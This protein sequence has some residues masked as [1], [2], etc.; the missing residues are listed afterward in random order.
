MLQKNVPYPS[1]LREE[2]MLAQEFAVKFHSGD[3]AD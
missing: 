1:A 2:P 3:T